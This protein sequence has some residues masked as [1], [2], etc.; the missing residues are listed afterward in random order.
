M[1]KDAAVIAV[2]LALMVGYCWARW[3]RAENG[4]KTAQALVDGAGKT[5][6]RARGVMLL[7]GVGVY[8]AIAMW[9]RG[10]GRLAGPVF[11]A[12]FKVA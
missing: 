10:Q 4:V 1:S 11:L 5:A 2:V 6:W 3:R 7:V 8:A 12:P 9:F